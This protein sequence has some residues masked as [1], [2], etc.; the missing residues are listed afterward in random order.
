[1]KCTSMIQISLIRTAQWG[2]RRTTKPA[3]VG[4]RTGSE[5][6][7]RHANRHR[8]FPLRSVRLVP[9]SITSTIDHDVHR[10]RR[11]AISGFFSV[12]S[13]GHLERI[14]SEHMEKM[15]AKMEKGP[16]PGKGERILS[17]HQVFRAFTTDVIT[18]YAFGDNQK[19]L[20]HDDWGHAATAGSAA[21]PS[22]THVFTAFLIVLTLLRSI[23]LWAFKIFMPRLNELHEKQKVRQASLSFHH[24]T[25]HNFSGGWTGCGSSE[26]RQTLSRSRKP[27]SKVFSAAI[28]HQKRRPTPDWPRKHNLSCSLVKVLLVSWLVV[29]TH[30]VMMLN[31]FGSLYNERCSVRASRSSYRVQESLGRIGRSP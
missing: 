10:R 12:A 22:L 25:D 31:L 8:T 9:D 29:P 24:V 2:G 11:N 14:I 7:S 17:M 1:M 28:C 21:W 23:P 16:T 18:L 19:I 6:T 20:D 30:L 5:R 27:F 26:T 15:F 3:L 13:I 4:L